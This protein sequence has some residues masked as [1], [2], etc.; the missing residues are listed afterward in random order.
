MANWV[1]SPTNTWK[2]YN[3]MNKL[4]VLLFVGFTSFAWAGGNQKVYDDAKEFGK[5][6]FDKTK[7]E[8]S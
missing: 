6:K 3:P 4:F 5:Q 2:G 1:K 7:K 8:L